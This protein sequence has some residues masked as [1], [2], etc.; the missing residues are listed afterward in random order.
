PDALRTGLWE[1]RLPGVKAVSWTDNGNKVSPAA[2]NLEL[3]RFRPIDVERHLP[4][5]CRCRMLHLVGR[6]PRSRGF[7]STVSRRAKSPACS[8]DTLPVPPSAIAN[9]NI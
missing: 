9:S 3:R 5:R 2:W 4:L 7:P 8:A 1:R 6:P